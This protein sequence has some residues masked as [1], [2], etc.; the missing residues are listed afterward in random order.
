[1][2]LFLLFYTFLTISLFGNENRLL[3]Y[4][5]CISCH[6]ELRKPSAPHFS[7]IKG[8]YKIKY[9][10]KEDFIKNMAKWVFNPNKETAQLPEAI[11]KYKLMPYLSIDLDTLIKISTYIYENNDF[12]TSL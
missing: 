6:G 4:G 8:F 12:V 7:E 5:N 9:P 3:F 11:K 1:M 2:K 10:K